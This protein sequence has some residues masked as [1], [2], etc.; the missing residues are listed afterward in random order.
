MTTPRKKGRPSVNADLKRQRINL[1]LSPEIIEKASA[2]L[3]KNPRVRSF[4]ELV[5]MAIA[6]QIERDSQHRPTLEIVGNI[7]VLEANFWIDLHGGIAAGQPIDYLTKEPIPVAKKFP[8]DHY[9]YRVF[10]ES[11]KPKVNDGDIIVVRRW[12]T[13]F[14]KKGTIVVY[15]DGM[16]ST[17]KE[18]GYRRASPDEEADSMGNVPVLRSLNKSFP[19]VQTMEGGRIEAVFVEKL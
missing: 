9:A 5:E 14:P 16:G 13:G 7:P 1:T 19:D 4:S 8:E 15:S 2:Y 12:E 17:L 10:G 11:M 18:F 3:G 6:A